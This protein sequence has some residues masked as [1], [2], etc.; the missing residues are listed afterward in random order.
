[1][2]LDLPGCECVGAERPLQELGA[3]DAAGP[4]SSA[5]PRSATVASTDAALMVDSVRGYPLEDCRQFLVARIAPT[6]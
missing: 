1:M 2:E 6:S 5:Q 3:L 4:F